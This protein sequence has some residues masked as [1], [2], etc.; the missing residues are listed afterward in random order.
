MPWVN[1]PLVI[2]FKYKIKLQYRQSQLELK[3]KLRFF[4]EHT[5][6]YFVK[7][8]GLFICRI[9]GIKSADKSADTCR[10]IKKTSRYE[11]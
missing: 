7:Y 11:Y 5:P 3:I 4:F 6:Q 9:K 2:I 1:F 10:K 8:K